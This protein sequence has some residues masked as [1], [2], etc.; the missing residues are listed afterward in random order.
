MK[1]FK[2]LIGILILIVVIIIITLTIFL[3]NKNSETSL[4]NAEKKQTNEIVNTEETKETINNRLTLNEVDNTGDFFTVVNCV[5]Q[6]LGAIN[7]TT[8]QSYDGNEDEEL[9]EAIQLSIYNILSQEYIDRNNITQ[10]NVYDYVDDI[11]ETIFFIPLKM[12]VIT[13]QDE[14]T[15]RYVVY[16]IEENIENTYLKDLYI[17]VNINENSDTFSIE[18]I[19]NSQYE[20]IDD[21]SIDNEAIEIPQND[22]N[23]VLEININDEYVSQRYLDYYKKLALGRPDIVYDLMN[24]EYKEK[25]FGSLESYEQYIQENIAD[26]KVIQ[27]KQYMVNRYDDYNEYVCK[28]AYGKLYIFD[29]KNPMDVSIKLDTY[30]INTDTFNKEY[31]NGDEQTKVQMNINKFVL[32][33]NNQDYQAAYNVLDDNFKNNYFKTLEEF[34]NYVKLNAYKYNDME[35]TSFDVNGN[36]YSCGVTLTDLTNGLYKDETK[37]TGGSGYSYTWN[38]FV[39]LNEGTDFKLSFEVN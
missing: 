28:D 9:K 20:N 29:G 2:Y 39:Q 37:G 6:Y 31:Q 22:N 10:N 27:L 33:I 34:E 32:M 17:I 13:S 25:R 3:F 15:K 36:V 23:Q 21:I 38:F 24:Q 8:I 5:N 19:L 12:N 30:T 14:S 7:K 4:D 26:V 35:V 18:P 16:G 1:R 11:N